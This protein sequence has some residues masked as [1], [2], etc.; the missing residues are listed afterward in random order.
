[1]HDPYPQS[2]P[3]TTAGRA[4]LRALQEDPVLLS[5]FVL[6]ALLISFQ[7]TITL[8]QPSWIGPITDWLRIALAWPQFLVVAWV[9]VSLQ[10]VG[11]RFATAWMFAALGMLSYAVARTLWTIAGMYV[12][13][14]GVP[15]P[16]FP[17]YF[18]ILQYPLFIAAIF[19][20]R[21]GA[22]LLVGLRT[23]VDGL[24]WM[25]SVTALTWYF[26]LDPIAGEHGVTQLAKTIGMGY[27][28]GDLVL[29][30]GVVLLFMH[31]YHTTAD[32]LVGSLLCV[33]FACL[34]IADTWAAVLLFTPPHTHRSGSPPDLFWSI[35]YLLLPLAGLVRLRLAPDEIPPSPEG[36]SEGLN[37]RDLWHGTKFVLPGI[38][39]LG[40]SAVIIVHA[41]VTEPSRSALRLP[42]LVGFVLLALALLRP[43]VFFVE[44]QQL[45][46]E[47]DA[48]AA[49][50]A[51]LRLAYERMEQFLGVVS[52]EL[53][54]PL[55]TLQANIQLLARRLDALA[56]SRG[57]PP[58]DTRAVVVLRMLVERC[59]HSLLRLRRLIGDM[60]D[61]AR[62]Q[63]GR[64][65]FRMAPCDLDTVVSEMVKDQALLNPTR[66]IR[67][68][69]TACMVPVIADAGRI[70]QVV[71]NYLSNALKFSRE[72]Q[73]VEV[74]LETADGLARVSVHDE[75]I[76]VPLEG[77]A[78]L[79]ERFYQAEAT[80][81]QSGSQIG[82]GMGLY[83]SKTIV[84]RHHGQVGMQSTPGHGSTF[85]F[86]LPL[87]GDKRS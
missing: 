11:H 15:F 20:V 60:L 12:Y 65:E 31:R 83:I 14:E 52:H 17:G 85:W 56:Q 41:L 6:S 36:P 34:L 7:L 30:Y 16:S 21:E 19:L 84:E 18:F 57:N 28:V 47:R 63:Q 71:T 43:V 62:I 74:R 35:F 68:M 44:Q 70:E 23:L 50:E 53:R 38:A 24:L 42:I 33:A 58:D 10:R 81:W 26:V 5:A 1:M 3:R 73:A 27:Q 86:T 80:P 77:Q 48:A 51:A 82:L 39:A 32:L 9:A 72:D 69:A 2:A 37:W 55:T 64:L 4:L 45:R 67:W 54:T 76:G 66:Q 59:E 49:R 79:W 87:R 22:R 75:G 25:G 13:P 29:F 78:H 46:R 61:T 40:A 8:V